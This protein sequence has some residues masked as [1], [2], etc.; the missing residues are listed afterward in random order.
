M[1][2]I[3]DIR[4]QCRLG[5]DITDEDAYLKVLLQAA[6]RH[7][8]VRIQKTL[9]PLSDWDPAAE[10]AETSQPIT[11][12]LRLAVLFLIG[13]WY[14]N[15]EAVVVGEAANT[16]PLTFDALIQSYLPTIIG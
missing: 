1:I 9:V 15:R 3:G 12:D 5:D 8:E 7:V 10:G 16:V 11:D 14:G 13:H 2:A 6:I 4:A